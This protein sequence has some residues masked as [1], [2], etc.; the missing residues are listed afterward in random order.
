MIAFIPFPFP[1]N[2]DFIEQ[3]KHARKMS[4][5]PRLAFGSTVGRPC[6]AHGPSASELAK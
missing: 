1:L 6:A 2:R 3:G 4:S 5:I